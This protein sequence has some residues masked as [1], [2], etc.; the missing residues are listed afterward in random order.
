MSEFVQ[1]ASKRMKLH[2][3]FDHA[4][5]LFEIGHLKDFEDAQRH[6]SAFP[7]NPESYCLAHVLN[8]RELLTLH[9]RSNRETFM[10]NGTASALIGVGMPKH[11]KQ[12]LI[13]R[14][15]G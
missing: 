15:N 3:W 1:S 7:E 8:R 14:M 10:T 6:I 11:Q 9:M 12:E 2:E 4:H 13:N 5:T